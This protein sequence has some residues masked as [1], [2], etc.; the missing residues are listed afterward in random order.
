M[1]TFHFE[2][3][4]NKVYTIKAKTKQEAIDIF[5]SGDVK[6]NKE[7]YVEDSTYIY[8]KDY[9]PISYY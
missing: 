6:P 8:D 4:V 1:K 7:I 2:E 3:L 5:E 9:K